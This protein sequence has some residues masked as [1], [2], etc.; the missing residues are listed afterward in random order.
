MATIIQDIKQIF[1]AGYGGSLSNPADNT[2]YGFDSFQGIVTL[3]NDT[4]KFKFLKA[5]TFTEFICKTT[6]SGTP[7]SQNI[8]LI[9]RNIT[10]PADQSVG[11]ISLSTSGLS[12]NLSANVSVN[13]SDYYIWVLAM[14]TFTTNPSN[15]SMQMKYR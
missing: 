13:T 9:L 15:F 1:I 10:N 8:E 3:P 2:E 12:Y 4:F 7:S 5:Q 11:N 6:F 14:P